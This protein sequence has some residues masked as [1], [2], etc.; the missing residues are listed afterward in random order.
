ME[1]LRK[2]KLLVAAPL[3]LVLFFIS[4]I[5]P[6]RFFQVYSLMSVSSSVS[7]NYLNYFDLIC[8]FI[9]VV[10]FSFLLFSNK[11]IRDE[12]FFIPCFFSLVSFF[13]VISLLFTGHG[14]FVP[15]LISKTII[16]WSSYYLSLFIKITQTSKAL[17]KT[18]FFILFALCFISLFLSSYGSYSNESRSGTS[19]FGINE[20]ALFACALFAW[21]L[22]SPKKN[23]FDFVLSGAG[24]L[25]AILS[26]FL[27]SSRRGLIVL[28]VIFIV[29]VFLKFYQ[30]LLHI[31]KKRGKSFSLIILFMT[32][33]FVVVLCFSFRTTIYS[34]LMKSATFRRMISSASGG[35]LFGDDR[36][37]IYA[38]AITNLSNYWLFGFYGSDKFFA[39]AIM[40]ANVH[41]HNLFLEFVSVFGLPVG[42]IFSVFFLIVFA[43]SMS[44]VFGRKNR[45]SNGTFAAFSPSAFLLI[46]FVFDFIG[47]SLWNPKMLFLVLF[48]SFFVLGHPFSQD[49]T[50]SV[51]SPSLYRGVVIESKKEN[52][53]GIRKK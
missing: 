1:V 16:V 2:E 33:F 31:G 23:L 25:V 53:Y 30:L 22:F 46:Y 20:S 12:L 44:R 15:D 35:D 5:L 14:E 34:L 4:M 48:S 7:C 17:D 6:A 3:L 11:G 26:L 37:Q 29:F 19:G 13:C 52:E 38:Y 28:A 42:S 8:V 50:H 18:F 32:L 9:L 43:E 10:S 39:N 51:S 24:G 45:S 41:C 27:S 47:Y 21:A 36:L 49:D 40:G